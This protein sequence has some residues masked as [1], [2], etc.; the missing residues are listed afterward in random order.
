M[1]TSINWLNAYLDRPI[2]AVEAERV[3]TDAGFAV[4]SVERKDGDTV[5]EVE[6]TSNRPDCLSHLGLARE[7][8]AATGRTFKPPVVQL[9]A[10]TDGHSVDQLTQ[11]ENRAVDLCPLYTARVIRGIKVGPSPKWLADR[12]ESIGLRPVNNVVDVTNFVLHETGQPLHAFDMNR[13]TEQRI[14]VRR[15]DEGESFT[16]IDGSKHKLT[17]RMLVIADASRPVAVAGIMGGLDSEVGDATTDV[18]LESA[19]FDPLSVRSTGRSLK[20]SS[21]SSY[22]FERKVDPAGVDA[23]S[24]RAAA[25]IVEL[26]G[27]V[28]AGGVLAVGD[29]VPQPR[30]ILLRPQRCRDLL[31]IDVPSPRMIELLAALGL[32]PQLDGDVIRCTV[33]TFRLDL[34]REVDLI[35]EIA[36]LHGFEQLQVEPKVSLVVRPPQQTVKA[37]HVINRV[38]TSHGYFE[39]ITFSN[40]PPA[41]AEPFVNGAELLCL[42]PEQKRADPALR[43]SL[44]PSL[45]ECRKHNQDAGNRQVRLFETAQTFARRDGRY[46]EKRRLAMLSDAEQPSEALRQL[47]GVIEAL[48]EAVGLGGEARITP[49]SPAPVW[50]DPAAQVVIQRDGSMQSIGRYGK[51]T[52]AIQKLFDLQS[53]VVLAELDYAALV[54]GYPPKPS[55]GPMPKFPAIE[56][57]LSVIVSEPVVWREIAQCIDKANPALLEEVRFVTVYRGKQIG[58]GR[59]SVTFRMVFRDPTR[60]LQHEEVDPAVNQVVAQL[61]ATV[62]G[63]V[64][65]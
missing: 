14:I 48:L 23:A 27:G 57:D 37:K 33:P 53:P 43:P 19:R 63:E 34:E 42:N 32:S 12:V 40:V 6:I 24:R 45:L 62:G 10:P 4:D 26:A 3:L 38:L 54:A 9:P 17:S 49:A 60:T 64:R 51:A 13:L 31:G 29:P 1:R 44:L 59:K 35:E 21:D 39:T 11:V 2:D 58:A 7:A 47:R 25:L 61:R 5:L 28:I 56:R 16:A 55:I 65:H 50:A 36:R 8:A 30:T 41:H 46:V 18:L 20:L 22:R 15:A 52:D